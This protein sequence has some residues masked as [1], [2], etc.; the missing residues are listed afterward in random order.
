M[1]QCELDGA[2]QGV[3]GHPRVRDGASDPSFQPQVVFCN[4]ELACSNLLMG[5][6]WERLG[7]IMESQEITHLNFP[8]VRGG[9]KAW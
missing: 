4:L 1:R 8:K 6:A 2:A 5:I 3:S 9:T 7:G